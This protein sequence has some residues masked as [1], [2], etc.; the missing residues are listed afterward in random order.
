MSETVVTSGQG[1]TVVQLDRRYGGRR[2]TILSISG[3]D[4]SVEYTADVSVKGNLMVNGRP[5]TGGGGGGS[6]MV[7]EV[8]SLPLQLSDT[9]SGDVCVFINGS[10]QRATDYVVGADNEILWI[11]PDFS[12]S[13]T[14]L[15]EAVYQI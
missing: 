1:L 5:I 15:V 9:P 10:L 6:M 7:T 11:S 13:P 14:D 8:L 4:G 3:D 12:I 2:Q